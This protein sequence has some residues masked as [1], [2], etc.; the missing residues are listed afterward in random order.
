[1][2][3]TAISISQIHLLDRRIKE[4][5]ISAASEKIQKA[6]SSYDTRYPLILPIYINEYRAI[7]V[8]RKKWSALVK[9][10]QKD[11]GVYQGNREVGRADAESHFRRPAGYRYEVTRLAVSTSP[12]DIVTG[13]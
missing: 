9:E 13:S 11:R 12:A 8:D 6:A 2:I 5:I 10:N 7:Y 4:R 3:L 1:V